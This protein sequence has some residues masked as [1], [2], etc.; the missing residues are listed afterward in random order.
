M[1]KQKLEVQ[2]IKVSIEQIHNSEY[3][4]LTD[5]AKRYGRPTDII[6]SWMRNNKTL[7]YLKEWELSKNR[8]FDEEG[9]NSI[10]LQSVNEGDRFNISPKL[11]VDKT[12]A[13]GINSTSGRYGGTY[14]H[15]DISIN[16]CYWID[17]KFQIFFIEAFQEL[18]KREYNRQNLEW[19]VSKIT[20]SIDEVRNLLDTIDG[21]KPERNRLLSN[22]K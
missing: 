20:D 12:N 7:V 22:R 9:F 13:I 5:I 14:A 21:Q 15:K 11:W 8:N 1:A 4:S 6:R 19:H 18:I 16:F 10:A 2:G 3:I 17:P